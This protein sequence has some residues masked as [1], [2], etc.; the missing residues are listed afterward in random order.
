MKCQKCEKP[1]TFHITEMTGDDPVELHLCEEHAREYLS[2]ND[3]GE[4]SGDDFLNALAQQFAGEPTPKVEKNELDDTDRQTCPICGISFYEFRKAGRLG[5]AHDYVAFREELEPLVLN[6]HGETEHTGKHPRTQ[7]RG[8][9]AERLRLVRL[10]REL[11]EAITI[12]DYEGASR[13]RD[14]IRQI[15]SSDD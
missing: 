13:M 15:E 9:A 2:A 5:C 14:E 11:Q 8:E 1:A 4:S 6:I 3:D 12:E 10:R 7:S